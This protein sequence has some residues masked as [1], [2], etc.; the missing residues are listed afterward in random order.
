MLIFT[1][2]HFSQ[3]VSRG[4]ATGNG[5]RP[6]LSQNPTDAERFAASS[7]FY[8]SSGTYTLDGSNLTRRISVSENPNNIDTTTTSEVRFEGED[9][10]WITFHPNSGGRPRSDINVVQKLVRAG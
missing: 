2:R 7:R 5:P 9:V 6:K 10:V 4:N 1:G 3:V 8:A